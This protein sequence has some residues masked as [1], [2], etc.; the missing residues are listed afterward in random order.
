MHGHRDAIGF[1]PRLITIL[2]RQPRLADDQLIGKCPT[3]QRAGGGLNQIV[4]PH[5]RRGKRIGTA[6][7]FVF[8]RRW[9]GQPL[10][11]R[12]GAGER[13]GPGRS[14]HLA[15]ILFQP[16]PV[17]DKVRQ[18][19]RVEVAHRKG[20]NHILS[21]PGLGRQFRNSRREF[22]VEPHAAGG[23][24]H[25]VGH[26]P[27]FDHQFA[28]R[29]RI[30][31]R[32]RQPPPADDWQTEQRNLFVAK[33]PARLTA[34]VRVAVIA[35]DQMTGQRLDPLRLDRGDG[36]GV[37]PR[38]FHQFAGNDPFRFGLEHTTAGPQEQFESART[39]VLILLPGHG[40][41]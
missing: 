10:G 28:G 21:P 11:D 9:R 3:G 23:G 30:D 1:A 38:G 25:R 40:D 22:A 4:R 27:L 34:P 17:A 16:H 39:G 20:V 26:Q 7:R 19:R 37:L 5:V 32:Q 41:A 35:F 18:P 12:L 33:G 36:A 2:Q 24:R 6:G 14:G 29:R 8:T 13:F 31:R 15:V